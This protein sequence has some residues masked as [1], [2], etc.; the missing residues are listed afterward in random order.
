MLPMS[1]RI[2]LGSL[3]VVIGL[4]ITSVSAAQEKRSPL[5]F[6]DTVKQKPVPEGTDPNRV[7]TG[8][9]VVQKKD[10]ADAKPILEDQDWFESSPFT[11]RLSLRADA[12]NG[13]GYQRGFTY[14]EAMIPIRDIDKS[15]LFADFRVVNFMHEDRWE[16]NFGLGYRWYSPRLDHVIGVNS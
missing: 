4:S 13:V 16:Y 9:P 6:D 7:V 1:H 3:A 14:A 11:G 12:G 8:I 10:M 2:V 5:G 15:F